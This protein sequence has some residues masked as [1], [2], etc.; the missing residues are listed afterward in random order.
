MTIEE[1]ILQI[2]QIYGV[3]SEENKR[4]LDVAFSALEKARE[5]K[6]GD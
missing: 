5:E 1:A 6:D 2:E 4:A 3:V